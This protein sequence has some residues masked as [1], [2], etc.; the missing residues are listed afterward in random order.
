MSGQGPALDIDRSVARKPRAL[1]KD[2]GELTVRSKTSSKVDKSEKGKP[3][4]L[5]GK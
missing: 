2:G 5:E 3:R 4:A 1:V